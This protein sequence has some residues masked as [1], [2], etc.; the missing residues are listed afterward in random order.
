[1]LN[2]EIFIQISVLE[3]HFQ[4]WCTLDSLPSIEKVDNIDLLL[5]NRLN[6]LLFNS[7]NLIVDKDIVEYIEHSAYPNPYIKKIVKKS[8]Q[9]SSLCIDNWNGD[10][11]NDLVKE[12]RFLDF[13][14]S[15]FILDLS[16]QESIE[17]SSK[18][19]QLICNYS[20]FIKKL[21]VLLASFT[22]RTNDTVV[23]FNW[24]DIFPEIEFN[25]IVIIDNYL[26]QDKDKLNTNII[27]FLTF[28]LKRRFESEINI[29]IV[30]YIDER[31]VENRIQLIKEGIINFSNYKI[32][33][34][35]LPNTLIEHDRA[36]ITNYHFVSSGH[37]FVFFNINGIM[38]TD[39]KINID[40]IFCNSIYSMIINKTKQIEK[41]SVD[42]PVK[43]IAG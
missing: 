23:N 35:F 1:M 30:T 38:N 32:K 29:T 31:L 7:V 18:N 41:W 25:K 19:G 4:N 39:T 20:T 6:D 26:L 13:P 42:Y 15:I 8:T 12:E 10:F 24:K 2:P 33:L 3:Q 36:I 28:I 9:K 27:S 11:N 34:I 21:P 40:G 22:I 16:D 14:N 37:G 43:L 17:N 5:L